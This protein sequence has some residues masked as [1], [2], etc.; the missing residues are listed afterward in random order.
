MNTLGFPL[1]SLMSLAQTLRSHFVRGLCCSPAHPFCHTGLWW[2]RGYW[3]FFACRTNF[4]ASQRRS[5]CARGGVS[6]GLGHLPWGQ[7]LAGGARASAQQGHLAQWSPSS[8]GCAGAGRGRRFVPAWWWLLFGFL[9][10]HLWGVVLT[11]KPTTLC[12]QNW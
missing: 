9:R 12:M 8:S 1:G 3:E 10:C 4:S 6:S 11:G 2:H 7:T 5:Q